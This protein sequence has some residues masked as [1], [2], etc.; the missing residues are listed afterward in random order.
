VWEINILPSFF[1]TV[2]IANNLK[3]LTKELAIPVISDQ[4]IQNIRKISR[5]KHVFE[6]LASSLAPSIYGHEYVKKAILLLLLGGV[7]KNLPNG[8]H[9]RG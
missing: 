9:L 3:L 4:D 1:R 5:K 7:E 8:T 2:L 6:T